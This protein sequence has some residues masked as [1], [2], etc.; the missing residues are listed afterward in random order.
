MM[1]KLLATTILAACALLAD[2]Q[3]VW[4][5]EV[6]KGTAAEI[7]LA[8]GTVETVQAGTFERIIR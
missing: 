3:T 4:R 8:D 6:A 2:G 1:K 7:R 5:F